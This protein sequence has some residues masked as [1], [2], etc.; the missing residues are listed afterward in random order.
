MIERI[1]H[2]HATPIV[3]RQIGFDD[4][5]NDPQP[6]LIGHAKSDRMWVTNGPLCHQ[7]LSLKY[8][9]NMFTVHAS[10]CR[11]CTLLA[12]QTANT[13]PKYL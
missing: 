9:L 8:H 1:L 11:A 13:D 12:L 5:L 4:L 6:G 2:H 7:S 10:A 3:R